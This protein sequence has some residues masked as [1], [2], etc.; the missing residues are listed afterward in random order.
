[1]KTTENLNQA[2]IVKCWSNE[3]EITLSEAI[4]NLQ[5]KINYSQISNG[6]LWNS[7]LMRYTSCRR[8]RSSGI[9]PLVFYNNGGNDNTIGNGLL[10]NIL[11]SNF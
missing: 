6:Q 4:E 8:K 11:N 5:I 10:I 1:M 9:I 7:N 3:F 2:A